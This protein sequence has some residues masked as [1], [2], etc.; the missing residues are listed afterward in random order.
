MISLL[1]HILLALLITNS[2]VLS[3]GDVFT[4]IYSA[5]ELTE[6]GE[7]IIGGKGADNHPFYLLNADFSGLNYG[8]KIPATI[9][10][11]TDMTV[12][13]LVYRGGDLILSIQDKYVYASNPSSSGV[14]L[15][16]SQGTSW[17]VSVVDNLFRLNNG[18]RL[19]SLYST[20]TAAKF[21]NYAVQVKEGPLVI[22]KRSIP[23]SQMNRYKRYLDA[24]NWE[25]LCLPFSAALPS[26]VEAY[27]VS[28][29]NDTT[30]SYT[31]V[32]SLQAGLP[33]IIQSK[34]SQI[35]TFSNNGGSH[36]TVPSSTATG[37]TGTFIPITRKQGFLLNGKQFVPATSGSIVPAFR[38]Y[39]TY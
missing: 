17:Q 3:A 18:S 37:F 32:T 4:R 26:G 29:H 22:Y 36:A 21:G 28:A 7:Y 8:S 31:A 23:L 34:T 2:L 35:V 15:H 6:D 5:A 38:C 20:S 1:R 39:F 24:G 12:W 13:T 11:S 30:L 25:T 14:K 16:A 33:Y 10:L 19:F 27:E 9:S